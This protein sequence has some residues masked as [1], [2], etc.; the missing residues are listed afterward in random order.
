MTEAHDVVVDLAALSRLGDLAVAGEE[1]GGLQCSERI[2]Q[3]LQ[4]DRTKKS[5][6]KCHSFS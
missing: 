6:P 3:W 1:A 2:R 4:L 5:R